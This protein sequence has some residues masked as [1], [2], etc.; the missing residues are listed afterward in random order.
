VVTA[1]AE[2]ALVEGQ[3]LAAFPVKTVVDR[4][5]VGDSFCASVAVG[6]GEG[7]TL[8]DEA[9]M[10]MAAGALTVQAAGAQPSLPTRAAIG[11]SLG[12]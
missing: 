10:G 1:G 8:V 6:V 12:S 11:S 7:K 4:T 9:R 2:G 5:G 3:T